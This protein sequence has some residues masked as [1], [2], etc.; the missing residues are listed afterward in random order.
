MVRATRGGTAGERGQ[1]PGGPQDR[2][3]GQ[4]QERGA[5]E[6][7]RSAG[8]LGRVKVKRGPHRVDVVTTLY[9][10]LLGCTKSGLHLLHLLFSAGIWIFI[11]K[12]VLDMSSSD[13]AA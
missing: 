1:D 2:G 5:E 13:D 11:I 6:S 12:K 4:G 10:V 8:G 7:G 9:Y 3:G